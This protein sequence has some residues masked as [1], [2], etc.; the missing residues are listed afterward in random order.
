LLGG[1][2]AEAQAESYV[3]ARAFSGVYRVTVHR[4]WGRPLGG[5]ATLETS[6]I[7]VHR[8]N[9]A[10]GKRSPSTAATP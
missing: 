10:A 7:T 2:V 5:K 9:P 6:S 8:A 4:I 1:T 3:A